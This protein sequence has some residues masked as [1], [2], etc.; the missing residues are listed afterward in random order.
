MAIKDE[1]KRPI[2]NYIGMTQML[3]FEKELNE[4][5]RLF[6]DFYLKKACLTSL[7]ELTKIV[8]G[9]ISDITMDTMWHCASAIAEQNLAGLLMEVHKTNKCDIFSI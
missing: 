3:H 8:S 9:N 6:L 5:S 4:L 2:G 1:F 7:V